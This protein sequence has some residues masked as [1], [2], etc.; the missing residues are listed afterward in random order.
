MSSCMNPNHQLRSLIGAGSK[1]T[2]RT[3]VCRHYA[4]FIGLLLVAANGAYG[5]VSSIDSAYI[6]PNSN[7][8]PPIPGS[9]FTS[10]TSGNPQ[11]GTLG[12]SLNEANLGS[13]GGN[14]YA[15]QNLWFFSNNGGTSAYNFQANDY[16]NASYTLTLSGG[17]SGLDMEGG[18]FFANPNND[19]SF[20]GNIQIVVVGQGGNAGVVFEGGGP[21]FHLFAPNGTYVNGTSITLGM[22]YVIDPNNGMNALQYSV[23]GV[24]ATGLNDGTYDDINVQSP[25]SFGPGD[26]L[27]GYFQIQT[28]G[29]TNSPNS[30]V[31]QFSNIHII[32]VPEPSALALLFLGLLPLARRIGRRA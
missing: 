26:T 2:N 30:G 24:F 6:N 20:G 25:N 13:S 16:F 11:T 14:G 8:Q 32:S 1:E 7:F 10:S 23:N 21:S 19:L 9:V 12:V 22:N 29:N 31:A 27:G 17:T 18:F 15:N 5:Q 4:T 3:P 28:T